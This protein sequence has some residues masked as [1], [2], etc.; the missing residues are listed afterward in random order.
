MR[1]KVYV[2][3]SGEHHSYY[4]VAV[5]TEQSKAE[6]YAAAY[7][8]YTEVEEYEVDPDIQEAAPEYRT[9]KLEKFLIERRQKK[10]EGGQ[11]GNK[12]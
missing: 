2:V 7:R 1:Q 5:F 4:V 8:G 9:A 3:T 6:Q 10:A 12:E 11:D